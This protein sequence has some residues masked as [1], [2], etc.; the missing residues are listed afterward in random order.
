MRVR[1]KRQ[2][3]VSDALTDALVAAWRFFSSFHIK[4][5]LKDIQNLS[6]M[7]EYLQMNNRDVLKTSRKMR[8]LSRG[9]EPC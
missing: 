3:H 5:K 8:P 1:A 7:R 4:L 6:H 2:G 9:L